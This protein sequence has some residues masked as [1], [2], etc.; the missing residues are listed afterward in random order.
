MQDFE[1]LGAFY[2]GRE[3]DLAAR[4]AEDNLILYDSKDL[5]TH[6]VCVGMTGSGKTGLCQALL[7]EAAIDGI[8]AI[9]IDPKGDLGNL[10]LTFPQLR[11]EDFAPW[12]NEDDA[13]RKGVSPA[14]FAAGQAKLWK[15]GLASWGQDG[16]RIQKL[17]DSADFAIYTP[18]STAGIPVSIVKSFN[19]PP[20][21]IRDD[22][23]AFGDRIST[24]VTSLLGL[25]GVDAD[26]MQSREHILLSAILSHVWRQGQNLDLGSL[27]AQIQQPPMTKLGVMDLE[28][29]FPQK[30][31]FG[32]AMRLNNLLAAPGFEA[33]MSGEPLDIGAM[34]HSP[35]GKPKISIFSISHL[36]DAERMFFVSMLLNETLGWVR[37]QPGTTSLR[38]LVYMDEIFGYFPPVQNPPSKLPLLTLLKQARAFGVGMVLATQNPVDLD[39]KGLSNCGTWF[40]GRLQT[41]R[42]K[43]RVLDGLEGASSTAGGSFNRGEMEKILSQLGSRVFLMNNVHEDAP[44]IFESRWV[45]SYLRGP[46][47]RNQIKLLQ[48]GAPS[49][50]ATP[51]AVT[52][53]AAAPAVSAAPVVAA[54][55]PASPPAAPSLTAGVRPVLSPGVPQY[56][57]PVRSQQPAGAK[58]Q[59][60]PAI[61]GRADI[62]FRDSK[63]G[64]DAQQ[65][66]SYLGDLE[67]GPVPLMWENAREVQVD[68]RDLDPQPSGNAIFAD[69]HP[70]AARARSYDGWKKMLSDWIYRGAKL[71]VFKSS[72]L[73]LTSKPGESE[74]DFRVHLQQVAREGRDEQVEKLRT[75]YA[76]KLAALQDRIRRAEQ[77]VAVQREQASGAKTSTLISVGAT[78]LGALLGRKTLSM[79][80]VSRAGTAARGVGRSMKESSDVDRA[81]ENVDALKQQFADLESQ[82]NEETA[83]LDARS[84]VANETL[85]RLP[86]RPKKTDITVKLVCLAWT[87]NWVAASGTIAAWE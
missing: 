66:Y 86:M 83:A 6:A 85:E 35:A 11:A 7:E 77:Q 37:Q 41:E 33:W 62:Y 45:M 27:I 23:E 74:R 9:V 26:P 38:A 30:D 56:F 24:T 16:S 72:S 65:T 21:A 44:V 50:T 3:Y 67:P 32:L 84:D 78:I 28:S 49:A 12:I 48:G 1:K 36:S 69:V 22:T 73:G 31:R 17:R 80:N 10:L 76:P 13:R 51:A 46:L 39:Y 60:V 57:L 2:L 53:P 8:P 87:P 82:F 63:S 55:I 34:L 58:L 29:V 71:E 75:K 81:Q 5:T 59:Y 43:A 15:D 20:P 61:L 70:E 25:A 54:V 14:D 68:E 40:I 79:G 4:K 47:T 42:D 18:G 64:A 19:A 52:A